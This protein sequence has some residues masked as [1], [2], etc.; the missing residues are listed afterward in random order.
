MM[1]PSISNSCA[2]S[3]RMRAI[4]LLSMPGIIRPLL[5]EKHFGDA[6]FGSAEFDQILLANCLIYAI[7]IHPARVPNSIPAKFVVPGPREAYDAQPRALI[8]ESGI[9]VRG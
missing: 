4:C 6:H 3:R 8:P 7:P 2:V 5:R 9:L 1:A